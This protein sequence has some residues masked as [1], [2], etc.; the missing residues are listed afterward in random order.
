MNEKIEEILDTKDYEELDQEINKS[1][2]FYN[3]L[4]KKEILTN[5]INDAF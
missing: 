2:L 3:Q 5:K 4:N 1:L